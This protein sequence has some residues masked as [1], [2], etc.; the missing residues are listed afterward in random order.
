MI[1]AQ[2]GFTLL[3]VV[4]A[5]TI[6]SVMTVFISQSTQK[7]VEAKQ[8]VQA[9]LDR[10]VDLRE[11]ISVISR[12]IG[13][14]FNYRDINIALYNAAQKSKS[15]GA[16][17][18]P[19]PGAPTPSGAAPNELKVDKILTH[20]IGKEDQLNFSSLSFV[21]T[22]EDQQFSDQAE[23]GYFLKSCRSRGENGKTSNCLWR[24]SSPYIDDEIDTGGEESVILE[25]VS[26]LSFRYLGPGHEEEWVRS[27]AT[28]GS[29][30]EVMRETFPYAV[31]ISLVIDDHRTKPPKKLAMTAVA[32]L[33]FPNNKMEGKNDTPK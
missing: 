12:D 28:D 31:E 26:Q 24:R 25:N 27:W 23:I 7:A 13:L 20:F 9:E 3:E 10:L 2:R 1:Q 17:P 22:Q 15:A 6:L 11:S 18:T 29:L 14:A 19:P 33:K 30:E 16:K 21:R 4:L 32:P 5:I 8:K